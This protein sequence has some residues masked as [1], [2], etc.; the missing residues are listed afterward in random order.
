MHFDYLNDLNTEQ[1]QSVE[2]GV[3]AKEAINVG[4]LLVI[5]GAGTG[6][7]KALAH[8]AAHLVVNNVD[9]QRILPAYIFAAGSRGNDP[10]G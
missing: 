10:K 6:K 2:Y 4:P 9:P 7:T 5:A 3:N 8:R 1:R